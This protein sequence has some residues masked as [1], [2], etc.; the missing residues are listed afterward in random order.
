MSKLGEE[1]EEKEKEKIQPP[2]LVPPEQKKKEE[3]K[4]EP[5][6]EFT[7]IDFK[8]FASENKDA[9]LKE[10][11]D[12]FK[13]LVEGKKAYNKDDEVTNKDG[14]KTITWS[15]PDNKDQKVIYHMDQ[16]NKILDITT[17][18]KDVKAIIPPHIDKEGKLAIANISEGSIKKE[19]IK[20]ADQVKNE[21]KAAEK[22]EEKAPEKN[23]VPDTKAQHEAKSEPV[24]KKVKFDEVVKKN[25]GSVEPLKD[26]PPADKPTR[27]PLKRSDGHVKL[28]KAE[29]VRNNLEAKAAKGL[30]PP[31][32]G[33]TAI[34]Q[35]K[36]E[37]K[38]SK[39]GP[40][41]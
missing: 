13:K 27:T 29:E 5:P 15:N 24:E 1:K 11:D 40:G 4:L 23:Q 20:E 31:A 34:S 2:L 41:K 17:S 16:D 28:P 39:T 14:T 36:I 6:K 10:I 8:K 35:Q 19:I 12:N 25:D 38:Q 30:P 33:S 26:K 21:L 7:P 9:S 37:E 22:K 18:G 3:L 32:P